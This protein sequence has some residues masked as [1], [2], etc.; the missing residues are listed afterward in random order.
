[1][2]NAF[3][4]GTRLTGSPQCFNQFQDYHCC[5]MLSA[6]QADETHR[7]FLQE[8]TGMTTQ[9]IRWAISSQIAYQALGR[10]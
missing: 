4:D 6:L 8:M 3:I 2:P 10:G 9:E 1:M 7:N 5:V